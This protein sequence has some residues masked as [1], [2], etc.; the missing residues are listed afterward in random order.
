MFT[1]LYDERIVR[2]VD[3]LPES[4]MALPTAAE[5]LLRVARLAKLPCIRVC[6]LGQGAEWESDA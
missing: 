3:A 4:G 2:R 6:S 1:A 5:K